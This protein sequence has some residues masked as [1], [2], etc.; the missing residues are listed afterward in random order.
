MPFLPR[1]LF[2]PQHEP[3]PHHYIGKPLQDPCY[4]GIQLPLPME[5][6]KPIVVN[7]NIEWKETPSAHIYKAQLHG[8]SH[9]EV[10]VEV[11]NGR[12]LCI[13]GEKSIEKG[14][15]RNGSAQLVERARGRFIQ[16]LLLPHNSNVHRLKAYMDHGL[17]N[18]IVPKY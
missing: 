18:I 4:F 3:H 16:R 1:A 6:E 11:E 17:L 8:L 9:N 10:R 2:G 7:R 12:E 13:S 14:I 5:G 15:M